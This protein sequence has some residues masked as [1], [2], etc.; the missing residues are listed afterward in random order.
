[1]ASQYSEYSRLRSIARKRAE[2]LAE[3]GYTKGLQF[4]T[5]KELKAGKISTSR[6]MQNV[7]TFLNAPTSVREYKKVPESQRPVLFQSGP[8][9]LVT[10]KEEEKKARRR[11]QN[12]QSAARYRE[13]IRNLTKQEKT[14]I[15]VAKTLG[16]KITPSQ[17][18]VF[19]EY[20]EYRLSQG[21]ESIY[22]RVARYVEDY[23]DV[24]EKKGY[25][26]GEIMN[27]FYQYVYLNE[28]LATNEESMI[29][30]TPEDI[31]TLFDKYVNRLK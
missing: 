26:P 14:Y 9:V 22:Y 31:E 20:M 19:G 18:K 7:L 30:Y 17:A 16:V 4:P 25:K 12:R 10:S 28:F 23:A 27:D 15:K 24:I 2:R 1:M 21:S 11:E 13:R 8:S 3:S 5:V 6:A 29:G